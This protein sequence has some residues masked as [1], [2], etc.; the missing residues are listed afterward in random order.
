MSLIK[1]LLNEE[2]VDLLEEN[3]GNL[4]EIP[5]KWIKI[6]TKRY[7]GV[8]PIGKDSEITTLA[9]PIKNI[10]K[11]RT[12]IIDSMKNDDVGFAFIKVDDKPFCLVHRA[13]SYTTR[14]E[15]RIIGIDGQ[16]ATMRKSYVQNVRTGKGQSQRQTK[17]EDVPNM[18]MKE[19]LDAIL[20]K[21]AGELSSSWDD[22]FKTGA[23]SIFGVT[24]DKN[25][26]ELMK[27]RGANKP[28]NSPEAQAGLMK[29]GPN[30]AKNAAAKKMLRK[31]A[32][33]AETAKKEYEE[34]GK[35]LQEEVDAAI[36]EMQSKISGM[37]DEAIETGKTADV[38]LS[39]EID[40]IKNKI[41]ELQKLTYAVASCVKK[42][43]VIELYNTFNWSGSKPEK[44]WDYKY[45]T[46]LLNKE[47]N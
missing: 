22:V 37:F 26:A 15:Y 1:E 27:K 31:R 5:T 2:D 9:D 12:S 6:L 44:A 39:K 18:P 38:N 4:Q 35:S 40:A 30:T 13:D 43:G 3:K 17:Y 16:N 10:S 24:L 11:F 47:T 32:E 14:Q 8:G 46:K 23:V 28:A 25:R 21:L 29:N 41:A 42:D 34:I 7:S 19:V 45:L 20:Y 33:E 36:K